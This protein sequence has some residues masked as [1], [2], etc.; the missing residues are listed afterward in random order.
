MLRESLKIDLLY[1]PVIQ[2]HQARR[3]YR[4]ANSEG[5]GLF[6]DIWSRVK[7]L[8]DGVND[9]ACIQFYGISTVWMPCRH[10]LTT[11]YWINLFPFLSPT[12]L[13]SLV[14]PEQS[15]SLLKTSFRRT[16]ESWRKVLK[17]TMCHSQR[18]VTSIFIMF[19]SLVVVALGE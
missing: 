3:T 16:F 9:N 7:G 6:F 2:K 4:T 17:A 12:F 8:P 1:Q 15:L 18:A 5:S 10:S 14:I 11:D 19:V 13:K